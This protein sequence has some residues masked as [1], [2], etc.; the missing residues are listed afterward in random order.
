MD[1]KKE[2]KAWHNMKTRCNNKNYH[3]YNRYG[4][5][6]ISYAPEWEDFKNF[7]DDLGPA[8]S[9]KHE[10]DRIDNDLGY[11]KENCHWVTKLEQMNNFSRNKNLTYNGETHSIAGWSRITGIDQTCLYH[12]LFKSNWSIEKALTTKSTPFKKHLITYNGETHSIAEWS[13]ITGI[14]QSTI[15][16]RI[17]LRKWSVEK[18]LT[19]L[20]KL[21][22]QTS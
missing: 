16:Q 7:L 2:H 1:N 18:A 5:R 10:L 19:T 4:G 13:R 6:G 20:P 22:N 9:S 21:I 11:S 3:S 12:R 14:K 8:P 15:R 17:S